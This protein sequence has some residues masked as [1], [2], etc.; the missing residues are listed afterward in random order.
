MN[1]S[2]FNEE[3]AAYNQAVELIPKHINSSPFP[4]FNKYKNDN[5]N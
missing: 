4:T 1:E 5:Q 3:I 2:L